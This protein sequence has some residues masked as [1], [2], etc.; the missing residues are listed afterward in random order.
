MTGGAGLIGAN[1]VLKWI[2]TAGSSVVKLDSLSYE[3]VENVRS[4]AY[5]QWLDQNY[6][7]RLRR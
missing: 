4:G 7:E 6:G 1:L 2:E 5:L 3:W